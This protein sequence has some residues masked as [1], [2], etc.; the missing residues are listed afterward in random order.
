MINGHC[1]DISII[2]SPEGSVLSPILFACFINDVG[3]HVRNCRFHLY[4]DDLQI[5]TVDGSG[6]VN[7]LIVVLVNDDLQRILD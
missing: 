2:G 3:D 5:Y 4:A 7:R 6:N 1:L